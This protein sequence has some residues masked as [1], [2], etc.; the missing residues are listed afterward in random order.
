MKFLC[1]PVD[2]E[3][4]VINADG[5]TPS[6]EGRVFKIDDDLGIIFEIWD[7]GHEEEL[8]ERWG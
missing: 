4:F 6:F 5:F 8:E 1:L 3:P 2:D 7:D